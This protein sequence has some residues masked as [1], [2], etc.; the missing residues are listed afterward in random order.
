MP[1]LQ[2]GRNLFDLVT[3][4]FLTYSHA[5][6]S[7]TSQTQVL[8]SKR[9][10]NHMKKPH[11]HECGLNCKL[12]FVDPLD[13][14]HHFLVDHNSPALVEG[15]GFL[16][17]GECFDVFKDTQKSQ[18]DIH[19]KHGKHL[20][21]PKDKRAFPSADKISY[22]FHI[23][24]NHSLQCHQCE[25]AFLPADRLLFDKHKDIH[26]MDKVP[27]LKSEPD[28]MEPCLVDEFLVEEKEAKSRV[29]RLDTD[30]ANVTC[31]GMAEKVKDEVVA[32][33]E[34]DGENNISV[35]KTKVQHECADQGLAGEHCMELETEDHPEIRVEPVVMERSLD[36]ERIISAVLVK[37]EAF[38]RLR[39]EDTESEIEDDAIE[40]T[41]DL[42][43][44]FEEPAQ[45]T[46]V[47]DD[48][49]PIRDVEASLG[50]TEIIAPS[51]AR[52]SEVE[53]GCGGDMKEEA[54]SVVFCEMQ[55]ATETDQ[56]PTLKQESKDPVKVE[57]RVASCQAAAPESPPLG[58]DDEKAP[59]RHKDHGS[60]QMD[61]DQSEL[62]QN[63]AADVKLEN[64]V[65]DAL[66]VE[67]IQ[68]EMQIVE[69]DE[70]GISICPF[71]VFFR[72]TKN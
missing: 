15:D 4:F 41:D 67:Q 11:P 64:Q 19:V 9:M 49:R 44:D 39:A 43:Y 66:E 38:G 16:Y 40:V 5:L 26:K 8:P 18:H 42:D 23:K 10:V 59:S 55:H 46:L 72:T 2:T 61:D 65:E 21:C 36:Q 20:V 45:E 47:V 63:Q 25:L 58:S 28:K 22:E 54:P 17:C 50:E 60:R 70:A 68:P 57:S 37:D 52:S 33:D 35:L 31:D 27:E 69:R 1:P 34:E 30:G 32:A 14:A 24:Q 51:N 29:P 53:L 71:P 48:V 6:A 7:L 13:R 56:E 3:T 62:E 12:K